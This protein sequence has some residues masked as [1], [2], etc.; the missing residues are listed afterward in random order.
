MGSGKGEAGAKGV[1][2]LTIWQQGRYDHQSGT[3]KGVLHG[4]DRRGKDPGVP[5]PLP[6]GRSQ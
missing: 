2:L 4:R 5:A 3:G 6:G 1:Y